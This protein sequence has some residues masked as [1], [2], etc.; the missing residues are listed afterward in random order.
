[1][2]SGAVS[3]TSLHQLGEDVGQGRAGRQHLQRPL[4]ARLHQ[5][6][7]LAW[8]V[9]DV[10]TR[11]DQRD[12]TTVGVAQHVAKSVELAHRTI[13]PD[14][15]LDMA[16]RTAALYDGR[17]LALHALAIVRVNTREKLLERDRARPRR[18]PVDAVHLVG[19]R[20][21][22]R[23]QVPFPAADVGDLLRGVELTLRAAWS[24]RRSPHRPALCRPHST[25]SGLPGAH[26]AP[27]REPFRGI[28][29]ARGVPPIRSPKQKGDP[30]TAPCES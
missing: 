28:R 10:A 21:R 24:R 3:S 2:A 1:M 9:R 13:R 29:R 4:F 16:E 30:K 26:T 18:Q 5:P 23:G 22:A 19:P 17:H 11:A 14:D 7:E 8:V 12:R 25:S 27:A 6:R 20:H 15:A